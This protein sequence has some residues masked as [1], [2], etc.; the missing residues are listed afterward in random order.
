MYLYLSLNER[1]VRLIPTEDKYD[2]VILTLCIFYRTRIPYFGPIIHTER[3]T[4]AKI[5]KCQVISII[6]KRTSF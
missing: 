4:R 2:F 1:A 3:N 5:H 6:P